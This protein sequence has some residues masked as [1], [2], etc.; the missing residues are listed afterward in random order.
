LGLLHHFGSVEELAGQRA[1]FGLM[2]EG[3]THVLCLNH[4][5]GNDALNARCAAL[6]QALQAA[7]PTNKMTAINLPPVGASVQ[8]V[9]DAIQASNANAMLVLGPPLLDVAIQAR[10]EE[11]MAIRI[12]VFDM[13]AESEAELVKEDSDVLFVVDQQQEMQAY[14]SVMG[15]FAF[16][17]SGQVFTSGTFETGPVL[18]TKVRTCSEY[19]RRKVV[20]CII[21]L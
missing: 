11:G 19:L 8:V 5:A 9:R 17:I 3:A 13:L 20:H 21:H 7:D 16:K 15:A 18:T 14:M 12:A 2:K 1:A 10:R 6:E 4:E